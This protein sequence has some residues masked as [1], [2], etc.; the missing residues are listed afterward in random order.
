MISIDSLLPLVLPYLPGVSDVV[1]QHHLLRAAIEFCRRSNVDRFDIDPIT[2]V[3]GVAVYDIDLPTNAVSF[4]SILSAAI[5]GVALELIRPADVSASPGSGRPIAC[6]GLDA[7]GSASI[8]LIGTPDA[9]YTITA[10][11]AVEPHRKT[12]VLSNRMVRHDQAVAYGALAR[13]MDVPGQPWS[14]PQLAAYYRS[15]FDNEILDAEAEADAGY[16]A[17]VVR[18]RSVFGMR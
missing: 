3:A 14:N 4:S 9:A 15:L 6:F 2:T 17:S 13:M 1:A 5:D 12:T 8:K 16:S 18:T 11:V 10:V 7:D